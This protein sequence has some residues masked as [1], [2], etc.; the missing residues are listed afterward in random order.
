MKVLVNC[1]AC[2]PYKGSEP[3]MGWNF[4]RCL[5][6]L[7]E[8]HIITESKFQ[9]DLKTYFSEHPEERK[10]YHFYFIRKE[11]HKKLRKI[12]PPSYYW[13]YRKWQKDA[14][15]LAQELENNEHF[16]LIHQLNMIG[17]REPGYLW[18]MNKPYVW[19]PIGGFNITPWRLLPSMGLYGS[20]F[21][22][23]RN[24]INIWQM[25]T[26][27][28]VNNAICRADAVISATQEDQEQ[29][30]KLWDVHS[31][32][33]TEVGLT[34]SIVCQN[35]VM[36]RMSSNPLRVCWSGLH[37]PRKSLNLLIESIALCSNRDNIELHV[38]GSG[39]CTNKWKRL[40][41]KLGLSN[42]RWYGN[43][44]RNKAIEVMGNS[45]VFAQTSLSDATSTVLLEALSMGIPVIALNHLGFANVLTNECGIK[46]SVSNKNKIVHDIAH[47]LDWLYEHE[48][49]RIEMSKGAFERAKEFSWDKKA[50]MINDIYKKLIQ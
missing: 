17:Y 23:L 46:I 15:K 43:I 4:V 29:I 31:V 7:H 11:R 28:R 9:P 39:A 47:A 36:E 34:D 18:K 19:G 44:D 25:H 30:Y 20:I 41:R 40:S 13:F 22:F 49:K 38:L 27:S 37:I 16:D 5:A 32:L 42:I 26:N 21:F 12:W 35:M 1:Y 48:D 45:H 8:L 14:F 6:K 33:I 10:A 50:E 24:L 3:G 2:S